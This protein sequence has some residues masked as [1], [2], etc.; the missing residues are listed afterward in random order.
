MVKKSS[1]GKVV[2]YL[3]FLALAGW[4]L[5]I[6]FKDIEWSEFVEGLRS[7][8]YYWIAASMFIGFLGFVIR[9]A[10]WQLLLKELNSNITL[11]ESYNGVTIAF[12][13]NF[14]L[15][16]A[17]EFARCGV[18]SK[19]GKVSFQEGLGS[20][21]VERVI[22]LLSLLALLVLLFFFKFNEFGTFLNEKIFTPFTDKFSFSMTYIWIPV[23]VVSAL[24]TYIYFKH[25][26]LIKNNQPYNN[27]IYKKIVNFI[28]GIKSGILTLLN[29]K[30]KWLFILYTILLWVSFWLT[31][32]TTIYAFP[33]ING[34]DGTDALFLMIVGSLGWL[35]PV[36]GGL[37]AYH[38]IVSLA[39]ASLY[40]IPQSTGVIFATISHESQAIVMI[41]CGLI[42][43]ISI[44]F[45][46]KKAPHI[47]A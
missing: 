5:Y 8:N 43:L 6:S 20:V 32:L 39:L 7:C 36:Q 37:G 31:S 33:A 18:I 27:P 30:N 25:K 45:S 11:K 4:L 1:L 38:F 15:P 35:V 21:V 26:A 16:R 9:A 14:V 2:S 41:I 3:F 46:K 44:S 19:G 42:S 10:R 40:A 28:N 22:D 24:S 47:D 29:L 23:W 34:L 17:G 12:L 13:A